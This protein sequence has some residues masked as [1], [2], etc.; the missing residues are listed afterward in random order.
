[1]ST[2]QKRI[3]DLE[4]QLQKL[5]SLTPDKLFRCTKCGEEF[6]RAWYQKSDICS[7]C[8]SQIHH[9]NARKEVEEE[10]LAASVVEV[11][12]EDSDRVNEIILQKNNRKF[13]LSAD[14]FECITINE[15][16]S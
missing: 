5:K 15:L 13:K 4:G 12:V 11:D 1:M 16:S 10:L 3:Q 9:E 8:E 14:D 6:E 2:I 7:S